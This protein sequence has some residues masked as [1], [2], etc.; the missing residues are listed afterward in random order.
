MHQGNHVASDVVA[1]PAPEIALLFGASSAGAKSI[2]HQIK[3]Q[4]FSLISFSIQS[5]SKLISINTFTHSHV[6]AGEVMAFEKVLGILIHKLAI[7]GI[8]INV[9][10]FHGTQPIQ[11]LSAMIS[12]F[13]Y[14]NMTQHSAIALAV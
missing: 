1:D 2:P 8:I 14:L 13:G 7:I 3:Q 11:C 4:L 9:V 10:S 5:L 6:A 12:H